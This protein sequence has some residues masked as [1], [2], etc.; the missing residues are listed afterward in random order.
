MSNLTVELTAPNG[1]KYSQPIGL[2]INNEWVP[3]TK[4]DKITSI[5]PTDESEIASVHAAEPE[6]VDKAVAAARAAFKGPWRDMATSERGDLMMNLV[7][8]IQKN[9]ELL[10]TIETWDNG[11][12]YSVSLNEDLNEVT[13]TLKY[14]AGWAD[15]IQGQVIDT[16]PAKLAYTIR[17]PIGVCGQIIPWNYP[18]AMAAWKLGP[19]IATGN[20]VVL[21]AAEQTPLSI[22]VFANLVKEAGFPPGVINILNGR[23]KVAGAAM[24]LH[25][26]IDKIA[27]T[28]STATGK[29]IMKMAALTMKNITLETG[30]KSPLLVFDDADLEQAVK[31]SH[32]GI[33]SNQGQICTATSRILVQ[34]G[35]Y[36]KFIEAFK[37]CILE[38]SKVGDPFKDDTY[39]GPQVTKAQY[40]RVLSYV[41]AGKKDGA[42]LAM[43]GEAYKD[44][45]GKGFFVSPTVFTNVTDS[46]R[47]FREEVFGP[48]VVV[49]SFKTEEEALA[50][51][52]DT[53]YGLGS[54]VFTKDVVRAHRIARKIEA[55]MVW[56]NSSQ[57]CDYRIPFG[58]VKQSGIGRELG[59]AGLDAYTN[60][61][62]VHVNLG[63]WL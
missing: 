58:G 4:G 34:E 12:P 9:R 40:E 38:T 10:A 30:G 3:G 18:L 29:E 14:Y 20:T 62:A 28:G 37:K 53:T 44:V 26:G 27:F 23:G 31:W 39:Q 61:K 47:I 54:A 21:K 11:K 25:P 17:E 50:L 55:G 59:E 32:L 42:T 6:D 46:M 13:N 36:D 19:A 7:Q 24:A 48:F 15:K 33:M 45:G 63:T 22:L 56:I 51:A 35:I 60:K 57:D 5:N 8:L 41:E 52:N 16:S 43:G 1:T 49:V 2:F